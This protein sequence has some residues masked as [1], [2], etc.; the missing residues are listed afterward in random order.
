MT[1]LLGIISADLDVIYQLLIRNSVFA[2]Y[3]KKWE[4]N[5]AVHQL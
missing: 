1:K 5:G 4:H 2:G 3:W